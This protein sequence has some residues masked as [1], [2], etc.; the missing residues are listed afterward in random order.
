MLSVL[1]THA[2][3]DTHTTKGHKE[4]LGNVW[5]VSYLDCKMIWV[6]AYVQAHQIVY[7]KYV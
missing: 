1:N 6:F 5:Y 4:M 2:H 3:T 7:I